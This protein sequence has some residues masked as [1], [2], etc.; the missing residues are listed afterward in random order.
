MRSA[1]LHDIMRSPRHPS[2]TP[3]Q[4]AT[5]SSNATDLRGYFFFGSDLGKL[6]EPSYQTVFE[7][8]FGSRNQSSPVLRLSSSVR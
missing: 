6:A 4:S 5:K 8:F 1:L 7:R 3:T 2:K